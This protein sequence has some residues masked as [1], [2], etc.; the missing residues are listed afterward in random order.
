MNNLSNQGI[1][2]NALQIE[3]IINKVVP[4]IAN[5]KDHEFFKGILYIKAESCHSSAE[6]TY[7]IKKLLD[8]HEENQKKSVQVVDCQMEVAK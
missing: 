6:F 3:N 2:F 5:E 8:L 7:F 1:K 4:I